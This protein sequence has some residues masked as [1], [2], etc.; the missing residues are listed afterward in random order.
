MKLAEMS[1]FMVLCLSEDEL[2]SVYSAAGSFTPFTISSLHHL[3][4]FEDKRNSRVNRS[5]GQE[6]YV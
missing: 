6:K 1:P 5:T 3:V 2:K 4:P